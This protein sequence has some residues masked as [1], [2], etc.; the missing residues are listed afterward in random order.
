MEAASALGWSEDSR[1]E[2]S[3]TG[4]S[5]GKRR[6]R[7]RQWTDTHRTTER[8]R[9]PCPRRRRW[10]CLLRPANRRQRPQRSRPPRRCTPRIA[11]LSLSEMQTQGM[12]EGG[13]RAAGGAPKR[14]HLA[15]LAQKELRLEGFKA[16]PATKGASRT[17]R[18]R[19]GPGA[20]RFGMR[21]RAAGVPSAAALPRHGGGRPVGAAAHSVGRSRENTLHIV[22]FSKLGLVAERDRLL[23]PGDWRN[24]HGA[25]LQVPASAFRRRSRKQQASRN[26]EVCRHWL[27]GVVGHRCP[28]GRMPRRWTRPRRPS[29]VGADL[30]ERWHMGSRKCVDV[31]LAVLGP[32]YGASGLH[33][34]RRQTSASRGLNA[35]RR[36]GCIAPRGPRVESKRW[37]TPSGPGTRTIPEETRSDTDGPGWD[38]GVRGNAPEGVSC[39]GAGPSTTP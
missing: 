8:G 29:T 23:A 33:C 6:A 5:G 1:I 14:V 11:A 27:S 22:H 39:D 21:A 36:L 38:A 12:Q 37:C 18:R 2:R 16:L 15:E 17:A 20:R 4:R 13:A 30:W 19:H 31:Q 28:W 26:L 3:R 32:P 9:R 24:R 25:E 34:P 10:R 7:R 35:R